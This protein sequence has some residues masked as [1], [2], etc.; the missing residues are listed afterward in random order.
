METEN[1]ANAG[2]VAIKTLRLIAAS[3]QSMAGLSRFERG[4]VLA[5]LR[6]AQ[7]GR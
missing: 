4:A 7:G 6:L 5:A 2:E 3:E 1:G